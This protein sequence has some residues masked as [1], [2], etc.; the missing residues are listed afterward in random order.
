MILVEVEE[1]SPR[2][3]FRATNPGALSE[4][5]D[6]TGEVREIT[7]IQEGALKQRIAKRYTLQ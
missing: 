5:V 1:P 4:E 6:L 2:T 7:H 3:V